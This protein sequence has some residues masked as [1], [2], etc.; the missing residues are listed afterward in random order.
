M[1]EAP[2]KNRKTFITFD[3][4][5][6]KICHLYFFGGLLLLSFIQPCVFDWTGTAEA[7]R[8]DG[9]FGSGA[10]QHSTESRRR[11]GQVPNLTSL[12]CGCFM[13]YV[14]IIATPKRI[15]K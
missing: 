4:L 2:N 11:C 14:Y 3:Y 9:A 7:W 13:I 5:S 6:G 12:L 10:L 8:G 15:E 1:I